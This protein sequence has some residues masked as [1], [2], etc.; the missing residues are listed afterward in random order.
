MSTVHCADSL[1]SARHS[2]RVL[3]RLCLLNGGDLPE[4][5]RRRRSRTACRSPSPSVQVRSRPCWPEAGC[6]ASSVRCATTDRRP[7]PSRDSRRPATSSSCRTQGSWPTQCRPGRVDA[8]GSS[9]R[10]GCCVRSP[11]RSAGHSSRT[12]GPTSSITITATCGRP[13]SPPCSTRCSARWNA[14]STGR[15]ALGRRRRGP[16]GRRPH[17]SGGGDRRGS[18]RE[19][20]RARWCDPRGRPQRRRRPCPR[21]ARRIA[22]APGSG[23]A[24]RADDRARLDRRRP[25]GRPH[26]R[27]R[28]GSGTVRQL[29]IARAPPV[30]SGEHDP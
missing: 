12:S 9:S 7:R 25:A 6:S 4:T 18:R 13:I 3:V 14:R 2:N 10:P 23:R 22:A 17:H 16:R 29:T 20:G 21:P 11:L 27:P 19:V 8:D 30:A 5:G 1:V 24:A 28:R 15:R 26:S